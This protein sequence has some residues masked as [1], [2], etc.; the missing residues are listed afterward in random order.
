LSEPI[1]T[2]PSPSNTNIGSA[3]RLIEGIDN[4]LNAELQFFSNARKRIDTC[5]NYTRPE[6]AIMLEKI[7]KAFLDA[8]GRSVVL[9][10]ITEI[11]KDNMS[12]CKQLMTIV[13]E[14]K[15]LE[16]VKGN[17]ML[18]EREY[19]AP[20]ILFE[21]GKIASQIIY[22]NQKEIVDQHQYMFDTLWNK[23]VQAERR[24]KR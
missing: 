11:T 22:S 8:K 12:Y 24:I 6:V 10:Y 13:D 4:V 1:S 7:K 19:L 15:H 18:S 17:F 23:A 2:A 16:G 20:I 21:K 3:T 5:M 14:L 9:R